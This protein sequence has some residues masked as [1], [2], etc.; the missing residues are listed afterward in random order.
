MWR[1]FEDVLSEIHFIA[2]PAT[3][4]LYTTEQPVSLLLIM[5]TESSCLGD[6]EGASGAFC[7][8]DS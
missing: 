8:H 7:L 1:S 4:V 3:C 5:H 6:G 2:S